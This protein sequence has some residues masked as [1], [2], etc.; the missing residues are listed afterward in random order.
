M[1]RF[2]FPEKTNIFRDTTTTMHRVR[3]APR[4][5]R[6]PRLRVLV[7]DESLGSRIRA[8]LSERRKQAKKAEERKAP[9]RA[10]SLESIFLDHGGEWAT[11]STAAWAQ[12]WRNKPTHVGIDAEGTHFQPPL[13]VQIAWGDSVLLDAQRDS[14]S[15]NLRRLLADEDIVK[16]FFGP[17]KNENFGPHVTMASCVDVQQLIVNLTSRDSRALPSLANAAAQTLGEPLRKNSS[18]QRR[19]SSIRKRPSGLHWLNH[20]IRLYSAADAWITLRLYHAIL[21]TPWRFVHRRETLLTTLAS[22]W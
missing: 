4:R 22:A 17:P 6:W 8:I 13:L 2:S 9:E 12:L 11:A 21:Q 7:D 5:L 20:D 10:R 14:L 3:L 19:F 1:F 15:R 18:V 16:I